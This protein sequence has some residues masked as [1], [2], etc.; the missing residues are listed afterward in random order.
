[1]PIEP[2]ALIELSKILDK[3]Q[4]T[5][6]PIELIT[7]ERDASLDK[8]KPEALV[9]VQ[10]T[11]DV[12]EVAKWA[13]KHRVPL[14]ARGAGTSIS[15][16]VVPERGGVVVEF[17]SMKNVLDFD[18]SGR[19]VV[20]QPGLVNLTL[21]SFAK[22]HGLYYPPD[23][24]SGR[25]A[26]LGGN[27]AENAG[28]P[29][30]F[31]Y[32]VTTNYIIGLQVVLS[33]GRLLRLG[34]HAL[35]Y[36]EIDLLGVLIGSEGTLGIITEAVARLVRNPPAVK[37]ALV[38]FD[39]VAQASEA[40]SAIIRRG[41]V[42][43]TMEMMDQ[44]IMGIIEDFVHAGLPVDAAAALIIE[45][46]GYEESVTPQLEEI[47][48]ILKEN[49]GQDI[50]IAQSAEERELLWYGRKSAA[51][52]VARLAP[53][54]YTVD[55]TVPRS[56]LSQA[57]NAANQLY[58]EY[59]LQAGY[60]FHAGDGNLHPLVLIPDPNDPE[61]MK[62]VIE[63]GREL[64]RQSVAM[65]GSLTG[66]H[67]IGI[68]KREFMPL[69]FT[70]DELAVMREIKEIFDP[71][72][73]L[74]PGKIFPRFMPLANPQSKED[75]VVGET[76]VMPKSMTEAAS[77]IRSCSAAKQKIRITNSE[78]AQNP[79]ELV[80]S[81]KHLSGIS[82]YM[83]DDL[84]VTVKAGTPLTDLQTKLMRDGMWIPLVSPNQQQTIGSMISTNSNAP[85]R[86]RYGG[87]R[88][89]TLALQVIMPDGRSIQAGR[90]VVK[91]V[92]GYDIQ[93]LFIGSY[94]T[95]GLIIEAT[96]KL[97][98]LPRARSSLIIPI[99]SVQ[100]GLHLGTL[101]RKVNLVASGLIL[102]H[103][104]PQAGISSPDFLVYTAEG[105]PE[106]VNAELDLARAVLQPKGLDANVID[107]TT[108]ASE[109]WA[110]WLARDPI[111]PILRVGVPPKNLPDLI[112]Q[113]EV[114]LNHAAFIADIASGLLY[115]QG[116]IVE[117]LRP[118]ALAL[119]GYAIVL[120]GNATDR[121]GYQ[122]DALAIMRKLKQRWDP[123]GLFNPGAF[124]V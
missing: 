100:S 86:M 117:T 32:G 116:I 34:G 67:G 83:P 55:T 111:S 62:R 37:T 119:G 28:G 58:E 54:Y 123:L 109:L 112:T 24:A 89:L 110:D 25:S 77:V 51:G 29:H 52:A 92:A 95:L 22:S 1:M 20:V 107:T 47:S 38:S 124:I 72:D 90:P 44:K 115:T 98:P 11:Q 87:V 69:M 76:L 104:C 49:G 56:K 114:E 8:G 50:R 88:D 93:K 30:C 79:D 15:G 80:L 85:L 4:I 41:L 6:D 12:V 65:G 94:G 102:C 21:D 63:S 39:S 78:V 66:E 5:F 35:D 122:P 73:I 43:A 97:F 70:A 81:T 84:Y 14:I 17:S 48:T 27:L 96:L 105:M 2:Q 113:Q 40:V 42:P 16:G 120:K 31:K 13:Y 9:L 45:T 33:D 18:E 61:L 53:A 101:L 91:N 36:P 118:S 99:E 68:E 59:G 71:Q 106:D 103:N 74:N 75:T 46:D 3:D 60:V 82:A 23:P 121:W 64:G 19:S 10:N 26:T 7:Y 108:S 57:L